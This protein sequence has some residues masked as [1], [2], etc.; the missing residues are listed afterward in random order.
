[1]SGPSVLVIAGEPSGD[2]HAA[3]LIAEAGKRRPDLRFFGI[4]GDAMQAAGVDILYHT[5]QMAV[6]GF[7]EVLARYPFFKRVFQHMIGLARERQPNAVLLVDYP[8]FN[9]RFAQ[10]M[11]KMGLKVVYYICPQVWAWNRRR[12]PAMARSVDRLIAIFP[13]ERDVFA[14]TGMRV[15]FAG[16][17]LVDLAE[18]VQKEPPPQ[19]PWDKNK[20]R[21]ALLPGS[22]TQEIRRILPA[23]L[24]T[25]AILQDRLNQ[26]SFI[27]AAASNETAMLAENILKKTRGNPLE[28]RIVVGQTRQILRQAH[29]AIV[30]SG[31]AT[32]ETALMRCPMAIVYRTAWLTYLLGRILVRLPYLGM[33]NVVAERTLC[34]EFIQHRLRPAKLAQAIIPLVSDTQQ[35]RAM[36]EG[37]DDVA[38]KLGAGGAASQAATILLEEIP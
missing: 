26:P 4:G 1:M 12:I 31:T 14:E 13:F 22:R 6:L 16:H 37:L 28:G 21:I 24:Q 8:G 25:A 3:R 27:L 33:V 18:A 7:T 15:D 38:R 10:A 19:L 11:H 23:I 20:K 5:R 34:P 30:A 17:P 36:L 35:R 9:L 29:A 2:M 32:I